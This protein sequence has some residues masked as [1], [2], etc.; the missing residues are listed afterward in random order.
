M[1][2]VDEWTAMNAIVTAAMREYVMPVVTP[3]SRVI[4]NEEGEHLGTGSYCVFGNTAYLL[5]NEHVAA[6]L[7]HG[8]LGH[9]FFG[10]DEVFRLQ[11]PFV[12]WPHPEDVA[13]SVINRAVWEAVKHQAQAVPEVRFA[14]RHAPVASE[15]LFL[16]GH[17]GQRSKFLFGTLYA[18]G[19]AY[20][21]Q[22]EALPADSRC[23]AIHHFAVPYRPD[24]AQTA[25]GEK[26]ELPPPPGLS[27]SLVWDTK[28]VACLMEGREWSPDLAEVTGIV[29]GWP[30]SEGCLI[31]TRVEHIRRFFEALP[32]HSSAAT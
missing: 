32:A 2:D 1:M 28:A 23:D 24:L 21:S 8:S 7:A 29:W 19:T 12:A 20:L 9:Q 17:A 6:E 30:S 18:P 13:A 25:R 5:T 4:T 26:A 22:E 10:S 15:L 14:T 11:N 3:I 27:G 16:A 31:A